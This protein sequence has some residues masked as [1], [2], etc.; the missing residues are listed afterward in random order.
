M[1]FWCPWNAGIFHPTASVMGTLYQ[2]RIE[3]VEPVV[4]CRDAAWNGVVGTNGIA[5]NVCMNLSLYVEPEYVS[6]EG[7]SLEEIP[8]EGE[9][10]H[11]G[12]FDDQVK[13]G[14]WTHTTQAGA[15]RWWTVDQ[16]G[17]WA[18]DEAKV[19]EYIAPWCDGWKQWQIPI[20]WGNVGILKGRINPNPTTQD[21]LSQVLVQ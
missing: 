7:L 20:G 21:F 6:F 19:I 5:G 1:S 16:T 12:Y 4:V 10:A 8:V 9:G 18:N 14:S 15:G 11:F 17:F 13:G 2:T 3:I